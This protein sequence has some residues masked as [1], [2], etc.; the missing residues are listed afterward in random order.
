MH[1]IILIFKKIVRDTVGDTYIE[2]NYFS[3]AFARY[4]AGFAGFCR[5]PMFSDAEE[6]LSGHGQSVIPCMKFDV[7]ALTGHQYVAVIGK[8][9]EDLKR[10]NK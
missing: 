5:V 2:A 10:K 4:H 3:P 6:V 9:H 8:L 1:R 7:G